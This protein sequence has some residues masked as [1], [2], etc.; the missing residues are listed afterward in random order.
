MESSGKSAAKGTARWRMIVAWV[1]IVVASIIAL[2]A[3][4]DVWVKRQALDTN[5]WTAASSDMLQDDDIRSAL[6]VYLVNELYTNVDVQARL[7]QRLPEQL[8]G[9]AAPLAAT[10]RQG[11][12]RGV[13]DL[14]ARPR[15]QQL[16]KV[17]NQK[18]HKLFLAVI[19]NNDGRLQT[20]NGEV[21]LDLRPM[22][23][24]LAQREGFA[25]QLAQKLPPDAGHLVILKSDQ[26]G[27]AQTAVRTIKAMSYFLGILVLALYALAV[28]LVGTGRRRTMIM[29]VGF[30]ILLVGVILLAVRRFAGGWVVNS[31]NKNPDFD[32]ATAAVWSIGTNLLRN[33]AVNLIVYGVVIAVA[34]WLAGPSRPATALR[35]WLAP[36]LRDHPVIVYGIVTLGLLIFL[37]SGPTDS[38]RLIPLLILFGFGYLGV[39]VLRRQTARE[40]PDAAR[41]AS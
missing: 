20:T 36:T 15:V 10:L 23:E 21:V 4:M 34:A 27:S 14:L 35:R 24:Q 41:E 12:V 22:I 3:A 5:N 2:G 6:S 13:D 18:A 16:W 30:A 28:F 37:A 8:K 11:A 25:G 9:L 39:E 33:V 29:S 26:L 17:A 40:F 31:L 19:D 32:A 38:S 1:L 7:E